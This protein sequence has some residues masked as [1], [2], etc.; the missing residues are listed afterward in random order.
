MGALIKKCNFIENIPQFPISPSYT[1]LN[2][3]EK[4]WIC[5]SN[6]VYGVWEG[7]GCVSQDFCPWFY[8]KIIIL[9]WN[10]I[11]PVTYM[12]TYS[13]EIIVKSTS[14]ECQYTWHKSTN[15]YW[16]HY[17]YVCI[18]RWDCHFLWSR[19]LHEGLAVYRA[20]AKPPFPC[21]FKTL[22]IGTAIGIEPPLCRQMLYR[23]S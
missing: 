21:Y 17:F 8:V 10:Q 16:G 4:F 22:S 11:Q 6:L 9:T 23:L 3:K 5:A 2:L 20:K 19:E 7:D 18:W 15:N 14:F 12:C 1:K 13:V